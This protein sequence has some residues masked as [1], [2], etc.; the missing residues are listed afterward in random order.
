MDE[1]QEIYDAIKQCDTDKAEK[2]MRQ[3]LKADLDFSIHFL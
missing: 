3:H 2:L 1:H